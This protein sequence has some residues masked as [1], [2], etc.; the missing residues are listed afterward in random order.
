MLVYGFQ[1]TSNGH[2]L[3]LQIHDVIIILLLFIVIVIHIIND[4]YLIN[5]A[6]IFYDSTLRWRLLLW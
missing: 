3:V 5:P 4:M 2:D 6:D 1:S